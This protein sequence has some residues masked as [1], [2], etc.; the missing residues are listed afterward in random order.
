MKGKKSNKKIYYDK[1]GKVLSIEVK[2]AKSIDSELFDNVV[3]DYGK[4]GEVVRIN[5]YDFSLEAFR[6]N[7]KLLKDFSRGSRML[8]EVK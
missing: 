2:K 5:L 3:L 7:K 8:L 1:E 4:N 6:A